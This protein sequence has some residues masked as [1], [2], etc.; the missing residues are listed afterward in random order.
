MIRVQPV[1]IIER[2]STTLAP[3]HETIA[4]LSK[5]TKSGPVNEKRRMSKN[6]AAENL[7][8]R[9]YTYW[10]SSPYWLHNVL[11]S[12]EYKMKSSTQ[13][14]E[15]STRYRVPAWISNRVWECGVSKTL[16]RWRFDLQISRVLPFEHPLFR[17]ARSGDVMGIQNLLTKRQVCVTDRQLWTGSTALHVCI[18]C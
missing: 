2:L 5:E 18:L 9:H 11:G 17:C 8:T 10:T 12:F 6:L 14:Q 4:E 1:I 13:R 7:V 15:I 16:S 3:L